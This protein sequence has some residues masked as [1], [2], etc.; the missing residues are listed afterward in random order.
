V[1]SL[2]TAYT[3]R[4]DLTEEVDIEPARKK[5]KKEEK[6]REKRNRRQILEEEEKEK[7]GAERKEEQQKTKDEPIMQ[8]Q[9]QKR[10]SSTLIPSFQIEP[11]S[12]GLPPI[13]TP[14][15]P[16][17]NQNSTFAPRITYPSRNSW[18]QPNF[19][20]IETVEEPTKT[21]RILTQTAKQ[22]TAIPFAWVQIIFSGILWFRVFFSW[23]W[24]GSWSED[25]IYYPPPKVFKYIFS[26]GFGF[27]EPQFLV[28]L[29]G[30]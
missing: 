10:K 25:N 6:K 24:L 21:A 16:M 13:R 17:A 4:I 5:R 18:L 11:S 1:Y 23:G 27:L 20:V 19:I 2:S 9:L 14:L 3:F 22:S 28:F 12:R 26:N 15:E 7:R 29:F 30:G 8:A